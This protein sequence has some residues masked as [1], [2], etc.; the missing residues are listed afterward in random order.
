MIIVAIVA[1]LLSFAKV[2]DALTGLIYGSKSSAEKATISS[3]IQNTAK[4]IVGV[5]IGLFLISSGVA[6]LAIPVVGIA[7]IAVG[8]ILVAYSLWPFISKPSAMSGSIQGK[9]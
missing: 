4:I 8:A 3:K 1:I 5:S 2:A 6:A 7:M 9:N